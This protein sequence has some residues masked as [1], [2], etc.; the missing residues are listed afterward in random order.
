MISIP[1]KFVDASGRENLMAGA[2]RCKSDLLEKVCLENDQETNTVLPATGF[3]VTTFHLP[4]RTAAP[5]WAGLFWFQLFPWTSATGRLTGMLAK[6]SIL[7][8]Q[9]NFPVAPAHLRGQCWDLL[10]G[11]PCLAC[12]MEVNGIGP[13]SQVWEEHFRVQLG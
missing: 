4:C 7:P 13:H 11:P 9:F 10:S 12:S 1:W 2:W 3:F 5:F 6:G 8:A